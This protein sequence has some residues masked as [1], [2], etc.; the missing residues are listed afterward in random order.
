ML[1][2]VILVDRIIALAT[3]TNHEVTLNDTKPLENLFA[4]LR[5]CVSAWLRLTVYPMKN[6]K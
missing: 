1:L 6:E 3:A 2:R 4:P 5:L